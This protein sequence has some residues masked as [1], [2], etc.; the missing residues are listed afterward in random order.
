MGKQLKKD[1]ELKWKYRCVKVAGKKHDAHRFLMEQ[2]LGRPLQ[3]DEV[4]HHKDGN[5]L[6]NSIDNLQVM[7][8]KEHSRL[9]RKGATN[10]DTARRKLSKSTKDAWDSGKL[11]FLKRAVIAF[12]KDTGEFCARFASIGDAERSGYTGTHIAACCKGKR[13]THKGLI[14]KYE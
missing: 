12:D 2:V 13:K 10:S 4:V 6:N 11:D 3:R 5:K 7:S 9:H 1:E 14:W 8:R